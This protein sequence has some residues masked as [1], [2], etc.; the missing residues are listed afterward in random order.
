V[1]E[2]SAF[3][4]EMAIEKLKSNKS[5]GTDQIPAKLITAKGRTN[6]S[7]IHK[8]INSS[9]NKEILPEEWKELIVDSC[10][11]TKGD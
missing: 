8:L 5:P 10:I 11:C 9:C 6:R 4:F 7:E 2:P 1:P 3:G